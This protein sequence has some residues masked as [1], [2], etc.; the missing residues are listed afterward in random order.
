MQD[1]GGC[2]YR[3]PS[4]Y[5][6]LPCHGRDRLNPI[7]FGDAFVAG[8]LAQLHSTAFSVE[9]ST[10]RRAL[11]FANAAGTLAASRSGAKHALPTWPQV[12]AFLADSG[13][14]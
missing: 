2:V 8:L 7:G 9:R 11:Q 10:I 14:D 3:T 13:N 4:D 1:S 12:E 5:D 6:Q